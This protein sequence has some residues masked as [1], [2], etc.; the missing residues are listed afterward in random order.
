M[1][2][3]N[4]N[5]V[6]IDCTFEGSW[7]QPE[8]NLRASATEPSD[9]GVRSGAGHIVLTE[10]VFSATRPVVDAMILRTSAVHSQFDPQALR[11]VYL[12]LSEDP[13]RALNV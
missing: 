12:L 8:R 5:S 3:F 11:N 9:C 10:P 1:T 13:V 4:A 6:T 2:E 7:Q